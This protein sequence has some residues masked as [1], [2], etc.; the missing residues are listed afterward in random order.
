LSRKLG[1]VQYFH[2]EK[3]THHHAWARVD[4]GCVT[5]AYAWAG[6][7]VWNQGTKTIPESRLGLKCFNY[8]DSG[9][10]REIAEMNFEK[11]GR[12]G[13]SRWSVG[14]GGDFDERCWIRP[15]ARRGNCRNFISCGRGKFFRRL[16]IN[17]KEAM[18]NNIELELQQFPKTVTLKDGSKATLRPLHRADEK[19]FHQ[20][21]LGIPEPERMFIKHRVTE[22]STSSMTGARTLTTAQ[23]AAARHA[24]RKNHGRGDAAP[25]VERLETADR[26]RERV[27]ASRNFADAG[28]RA[29]SSARRWRSPGARDWK[30]SR[31]N[32]SAS[33][34]AA[35]KMFAMLGFSQ[36][37]RLEDYVKDMQA[38][39]HDYILMGL[40]L[41]TDEEYA[42]A[43]RI[44]ESTK[45]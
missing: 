16:H 2:A 15:A 38:I 21:F 9:A 32:S 45:K 31:R 26:A 43:R 7:T 5:R 14:P 36:L 23:P 37:M 29:R 44:Y 13:G 35:M 6:E 41:R 10:T 33:S 40:D 39:S 27:G 24:R 28:W 4:D 8:G 11:V 30:G 34:T 19:D 20:L 3:F 25:A 22:I 1:H 12:A 18:S 17:K 42:S